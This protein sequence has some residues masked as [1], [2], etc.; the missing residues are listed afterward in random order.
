MRIIESSIWV[1][2][3]TGFPAA[4][5]AL[6]IIFCAAKTW[7]GGGGQEDEARGS[8]SSVIDPLAIDP[9]G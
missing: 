2:T 4:L 5:H 9:L 8:R 3:M 1:A 6:T 7:R